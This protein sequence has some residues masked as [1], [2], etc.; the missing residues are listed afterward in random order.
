MSET[1]KLLKPA[2]STADAENPSFTLRDGTLALEFVDWQKRSVHVRFS[3]AAAVKWQELDSTGPEDRDDS[4]YEIVGSRWLHDYLATLA[5][6][7]ADGLHHYRLCFNGSGV[8][9]VL[10]QSMNMENAG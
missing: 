5:R 7:P 10:A 9:D 4:V 1:A 2:F 6:T 8:L 3:N